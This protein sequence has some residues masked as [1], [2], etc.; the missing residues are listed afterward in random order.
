MICHNGVVIKCLSP[1]ITLP[2]PHTSPEARTT[3]EIERQFCNL[4]F[5]AVRMG[6]LFVLVIVFQVSVV[7]LQ[8]QFSTPFLYSWTV[9]MKAY[10]SSRH[11]TWAQLAK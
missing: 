3:L 9:L 11:L 6:M 4:M 7:C 10:F 5:Q 2:L 1:G 8:T